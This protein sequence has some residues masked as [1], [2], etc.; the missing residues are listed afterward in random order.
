M[1]REQLQP[2]T[3]N[4]FAIDAA[5]D[6]TYLYNRL[7]TATTDD[8][9]RF[10]LR[11]A[12]RQFYKK[13]IKGDN[14]L[15]IPVKQLLEEEGYHLNPRSDYD[16]FYEAIENLGIP[17]GKVP[18]E[19]KNGKQAG[20]K[21][22]HFVLSKDRERV[23]QGLERNEKLQRS[24]ESAVKHFETT[25]IGEVPSA[26]DLV[27]YGYVGGVAKRLKIPFTKRSK[28]QQKDLLEHCPV[29]IE[30]YDGRFRFPKGKEQELGEFL[31]RRYQE[32]S[33]Y[34]HSLLDEFVKVW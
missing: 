25:Q 3:R 34:K 32:R 11:I 16:S 20:E 12:T 1:R 2:E 4:W 33:S 24:K 14:P 13:H 23:I 15:L 21:F 27:N 18:M 28:I 5:R 17:L 26:R 6:Q 9:R 8:T 29:P 10:F 30:I 31:K 7:L 19:V 22:Y